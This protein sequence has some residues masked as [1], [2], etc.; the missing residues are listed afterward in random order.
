MQRVV[1]TA[2]QRL[3][4]N[5]TSRSNSANCASLHNMMTH[6]VLLSFFSFICYKEFPRRPYKTTSYTQLWP[7]CVDANFR[8]SQIICGTFVDLIRNTNESQNRFIHADV[9][10]NN[11][12]I[13]G[14]ITRYVPHIKYTE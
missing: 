8:I 6:S 13:D 11:W 4:A 3:N 2:T 1:K 10:K 14:I 9:D 5:G 12:K 7:L